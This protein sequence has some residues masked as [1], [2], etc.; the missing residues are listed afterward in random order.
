MFPFRSKKQAMLGLDISTTAVKLLELSRSSSRNGMRY[1][2]EAYAVEP[3]QANA[4]VE[5]NIADVEAVG[6]AIKNVV[7]RAGTNTK[8]AVVAVSGSAVI[9]KTIT[10]PAS[11]SDK[12][13][14]NQIQ[15]EAD[16]YI[17]YPLEEV[18]L[19]FEVLGVSEK[20]PEMVDVLLA[21]SRSEN[22][23]DRVAALEMAGLTAAV[24][25]VE[26]YAMENAFSQ[27][28][29]QLP[30]GSEEL[31]IAI[32]DIG[33]TIT[34][35][36]VLHAGKIIYTR[37]QNFGG[38]QLTEE[39]QR[40]YGL[41]HSEAGMAKRQGGLPDN[42][43]PDVLEP[44]KEAMAQQVSRSLQ[45]FFSSSAYNS[46][47]VIVLAG[48]C[49]SIPGVD[50]LLEQRMGTPAIIANPF[51]NMSV[52]SNVKPQSLNNDAPALMIACGLALRSFD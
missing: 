46:V 47:D 15:L 42:Y 4:V 30:E 40:R 31:T 45:F 33:A 28:V 3:L 24:V 18:N 34:T 44:F 17:P 21:A 20:N 23:D 22:V 1:Q 5:K 16:Q 13:M 7:K 36:N 2:V 19:D 25:D 50:K 26:A 32:A 27:I 11:L 48:G 37:E 38:K 29:D 6:Q 14:E 51:A 39:I 49:S 12:E 9:T 41:S 35:L 52:S 8:Q 10:M 43:G